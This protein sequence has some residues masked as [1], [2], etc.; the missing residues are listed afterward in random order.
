MA[1]GQR[2]SILTH[3]NVYEY[4]GKLKYFGGYSRHKQD[5][6][7]SHRINRAHEKELFIKMVAIEEVQ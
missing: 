2:A 1:T 3:R 6:K 4:W 7:I 5:K